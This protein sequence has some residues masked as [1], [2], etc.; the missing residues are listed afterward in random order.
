MVSYGDPE[1]V[2]APVWP[3]TS[4]AKVVDAPLAYAPV[5]LVDPTYGA[6]LVE[7]N[8]EV[9]VIVVVVVLENE[10]D[11]VLE[12]EPAPRVIPDDGSAELEKAVE[13]KV[14]VRKV[15]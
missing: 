9:E 14:R 12:E 6:V 4:V 13:V 5:P 2:D 10:V 7:N 1:C 3:L 11:I 8:V 15:S